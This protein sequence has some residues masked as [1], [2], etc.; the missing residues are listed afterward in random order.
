M[1]MSSYNGIDL[2]FRYETV[3]T[4]DHNMLQE[5]IQFCI[6]KLNI[7]RK[8]FRSLLFNFSRRDDIDNTG[9]FHYRHM[10]GEVNVHCFNDIH[11]V[12]SIIA[13]EMIHAQQWG[14]GRLS[15]QYERVGNDH[16]KEYLH[17]EGNKVDHDTLAYD[18]LPWEIEAHHRQIMLTTEYVI[19]NSCI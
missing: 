17:W 2:R 15:R 1:L 14:T 11:V 19:E 13:H 16:V 6:D 10:E 18:E 8:M 9:S 4:E 5:F 12:H 7:T 3:V